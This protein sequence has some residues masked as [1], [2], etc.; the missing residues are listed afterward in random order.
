MFIFWRNCLQPVGFP[1]QFQC[2]ADM[3]SHFASIFIRRRVVANLDKRAVAK[4]VCLF[5]C[6]YFDIYVAEGIVGVDARI[7]RLFG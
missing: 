3:R 2:H 4:C 7:L 1:F 5:L 6:F